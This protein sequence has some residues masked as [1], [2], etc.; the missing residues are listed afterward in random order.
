MLFYEG[1]ETLFGNS[2]MTYNMRIIK[3]SLTNKR[4][5]LIEMELAQSNLSEFLEKKI[6]PD[7]D[8]LYEII[9]E[10]DFSDIC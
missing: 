6:N 2:V 3:D 9:S 1:L 10:E 7:T 8:K 4:I 5:A